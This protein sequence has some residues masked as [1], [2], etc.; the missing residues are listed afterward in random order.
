[1]RKKPVI[2]KLTPHLL[3]DDERLPL[4]FTWNGF[5]FTRDR[6]F[7][8]RFTAKGKTARDEAFIIELIGPDT[9][10]LRLWTARIEVKR[11]MVEGA[12]D[13]PTAA[14]GDLRRDL[15]RIIRDGEF[16]DRLLWGLT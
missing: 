14:L 1:M 7:S 6:K 2:P 12:A 15:A 11:F 9:L 8:Y 5:R 13:T 10:A 4:W 16:A 3:D